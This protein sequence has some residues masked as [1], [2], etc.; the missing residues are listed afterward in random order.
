MPPPWYGRK[1]KIAKTY[2]S[3]RVGS[4]TLLWHIF[5]LSVTSID[6]ILRITDSRRDSKPGLSEFKTVLTH[7]TQLLK[8][9]R[10]RSVMERVHFHS[11][12][13]VYTVNTHCSKASKINEA[14]TAKFRDA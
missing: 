9:I 10:E 11:C 12:F 6:I 14:S 4:D 2:C 1:L 5:K 13:N 3:Y 8:N 7:T